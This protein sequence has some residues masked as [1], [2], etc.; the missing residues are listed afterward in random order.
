MDK[1]RLGNEL[2]I[3]MEDE[4]KDMKLSQG[5]RDTI[6]IHRK[7][8]L[9]DK[10]RGF[11]NKEIELPLIPIVVG[12][13]LL[14]IIAGVPKDIIYRRENVRIVDIGSSQMI[15]RDERRVNPRHEN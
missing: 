4:T 2:K 10:I 13:A 9:R 12:S 15:I 5:L 6:L 8:T 11:L 7:K 3:I 1:D 14:F